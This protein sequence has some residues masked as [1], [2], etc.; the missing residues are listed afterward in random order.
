MTKKLF[1]TR[2]KKVIRYYKNLGNFSETPHHEFLPTPL[3]E[4][5]AELAQV[6]GAQPNKHHHTKDAIL[7]EMCCGNG[8]RCHTSR[9]YWDMW[10]NFLNQ[11]ISRAAARWTRLNFSIRTPGKPAKMEL[12]Q[13]RRLNTKHE[14]GKQQHYKSKSEQ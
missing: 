9:I 11:P 6:G 14:Q 2:L 8:S 12:Q 1:W 13:S 3:R 10:S 5:A 4:R 7:Y